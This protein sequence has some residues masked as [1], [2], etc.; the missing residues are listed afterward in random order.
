MVSDITKDIS[1]DY[2][3]LLDDSISLRAT[4]F[5]DR[6]GLVRFYSVNDLQIGRNIEEIIRIIEAFKYN[7]ETDGEVCPMNWKK[8]DT[9]IKIK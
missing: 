5:I 7:N 2:C 6:N 4:F 1:R 3:I 9:G 8:G